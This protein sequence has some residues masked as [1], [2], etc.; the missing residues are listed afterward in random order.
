MTTQEINRYIAV[1]S[2]WEEQY[3]IARTAVN[4]M[5]DRVRE[6]KETLKAQEA[7]I[8]I[9]ESQ[10]KIQDNAILRKDTEIKK[11]KADLDSAY[12]YVFWFGA[13]FVAASFIIAWG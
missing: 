11:L 4:M 7:F 3:S 9:L 12:D 6:H 13:G 1:A 5:Q 2:K 10:L 8:N